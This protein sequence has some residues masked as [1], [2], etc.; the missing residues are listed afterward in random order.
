MIA[1]EDQQRLRPYLLPGERLLWTGRP[2]RGIAFQRQDV[3][4]LPLL[5]AGTA[6][7]LS[8][9]PIAK[10][11]QL[12]PL[13]FFLAAA[14]LYVAGAR[15]LYEPWL[16]RNLVYALTSQRVL[17]LSGRL[18]PRLS[19]H[20]LGWLPMLVLEQESRDRATI[21]IEEGETTEGWLARAQSQAGDLAKGFRFYRI[22]KP[23]A[24]YDLICR[25]SRDRR[26]ELNRVSTN[27]L[28]G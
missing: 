15:F 20:D 4:L 11:L 3:W 1:Y 22:E 7:N 25:A 16:R 21:L 10:V 6:I 24:V 9:F 14:L 18:R 12:Q 19:S 5:A 13:T 27:P 26:A 23:G 8:A 17:I 2:Q 28:I